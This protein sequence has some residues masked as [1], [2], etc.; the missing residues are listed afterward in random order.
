M[1]QDHKRRWSVEPGLQQSRALTT[2]SDCWKGRWIPRVGDI[3]RGQ[4]WQELWWRK[5]IPQ[6]VQVVIKNKCTAA[7]LA[8]EHP[9]TTWLKEEIKQLFIKKSI[10][11]GKLYN[12]I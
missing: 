5:I 6:F 7:Q 11:N 4:L 12:Y 3:G 2:G 1:Y 10:L 8:K 9:Q